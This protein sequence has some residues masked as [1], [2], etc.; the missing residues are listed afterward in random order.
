MTLIETIREEAFVPE[1]ARPTAV[2]QH[3]ALDSSAIHR[4]YRILILFSAVIRRITSCEFLSKA[5]DENVTNA[6][7]DA[8]RFIFL[9]EDASISDVACGLGYTISGATKAIDRLAQKGWAERR[10]QS[11]D[12]REVHV[13]LTP[14]GRH[15]ALQIL[16]AT[17]EQLEEL[18]ERLPPTLAGELETVLEKSIG[19]FVDGETTARQL[20]VACG[21]E[22]G[23]DCPQSHTDCVVAQSNQRCGENAEK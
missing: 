17:G 2:E 4:R 12:L 19:H 8:L 21:F 1:A 7:A 13:R 23:I 5:I 6:Q 16:I 9:N 10:S 11:K 18:F 3:H 15:L 14:R 22:G 20:C